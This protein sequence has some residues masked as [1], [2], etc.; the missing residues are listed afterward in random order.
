MLK[1]HLR[2]L[3]EQL[4]V[5]ANVII[6]GELIHNLRF[7]RSHQITLLEFQINQI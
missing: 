4:Y 2:V 1:F 7:I 6:V 3:K 5:S